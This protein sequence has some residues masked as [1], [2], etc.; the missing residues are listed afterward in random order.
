VESRA[1][2]P[3]PQRAFAPRARLRTLSHVE[4]A[5]WTLTTLLILAGLVGS[6]VPM[7]PG[8]TLIFAG[9][10]LHKLLLPASVSTAAIVWIGVFWVLSVLADFAC[11]LLGARLFGGSKWGM[12]GAGGGALVGMFFS[13][14]ALLLGTILGAV[15][16]EKL[17]GKRTDKDA[18]KSGLGA[19][20]GFLVSTVVR[21]AFA[22]AMVALFAYSAITI[23]SATAP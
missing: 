15:A 2:F 10:L 11:T 14:P 17:V 22:V 13:L 8:T 19:A 6:V 1:A 3:N 16:A 5:L 23:A 18:L 12:T 4:Y 21:A 20:L 9:A 7:L